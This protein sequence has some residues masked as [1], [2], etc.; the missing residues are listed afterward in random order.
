MHASVSGFVEYKNA[1]IEVIY[2]RLRALELLT[3]NMQQETSRH[4]QN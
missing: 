3:N 4:S 1:E 2:C